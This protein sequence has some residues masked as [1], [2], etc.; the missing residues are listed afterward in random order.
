VAGDPRAALEYGNPWRGRDG[1]CRF[2]EEIFR[3]TTGNHVEVVNLEAHEGRV[4]ASVYLHGT[5]RDT[6]VSGALP[7]VHVFTIRD[8][9]IARNEIHRRGGDED[10]S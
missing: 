3:Q 10:E 7:S 1:V 6:G 2:F 9:L 4:I 5:F 8:G